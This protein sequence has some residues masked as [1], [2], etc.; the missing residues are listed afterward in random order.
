M[1]EMPP[2]APENVLIIADLHFGIEH[3][4]E[5]AGARL[6]SQTNQ[7]TERILKLCSKL[8]ISQLILL[9]D[10]KHTVPATS[11]QEWRELPKVFSKLLTA[12]E[13]IDIIPG[14][15]DGNLRR[16]IPQEFEGV[17]FHSASGTVLHGLG[18]FHGHTWPSAEVLTAK[19]VLMAH[20]HPNVLFI[21]KLGG[22]ASYSCWL[23][24]R[25]DKELAQQRYPKV[26]DDDPE[27]IVMPAFNDIGSGTPVNTMKPEFLGPML[28]NHYLDLDSAH[29]YLLDGTDLGALRTLVD[30]SS[31]TK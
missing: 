31:I 11:R 14:N 10:I 23:R 27:I 22:R 18:L 15:H 2:G 5:L 30:L 3:S 13:T 19:Q 4:L 21:D 29:V 9:G 20:N 8:D 12:V 1:L 28:K 7:I 17:H 25:L 16:L 6:P 26:V 24:C